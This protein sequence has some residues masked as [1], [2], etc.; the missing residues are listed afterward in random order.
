MTKMDRTGWGESDLYVLRLRNKSYH[1]SFLEE[2]GFISK[3]KRGAVDTA[4][5]VQAARKDIV[6]LDEGILKMAVGDNRSIHYNAVQ[7]SLKRHGGIARHRAQMLYDDTKDARI[8]EALGFFYDTVETNEDG[9]EQPTYDLS[10]PANVTYTA[11]GFLSHNTIGLLMDCD[12]TGIEPDFALVKFKK[13]AGGGYFK[14]V[15]QSIPK[16]LKH[17]GYTESQSKEIITYILGTSS[18]KKAPHIREEVLRAK[19]FNKDD[20]EK[21]ERVLPGSFELTQ[22]FSTHTLGKETMGRFGF[23][24]DQY[25]KPGFNLLKALGFS[26]PQIEEASLVICGRMTI[27][28]APHLCKEHLPIF[29]CAN[30]CGG[31]GKRYLAPMSHIRMMSSAQKFISGAISKTINLPNETTVED[32]EKL[33]VETWKLGLKS[34]ALY[35]DGCKLSQP[36]NATNDKQKETATETALAAQQQPTLKRHRLSKKRR[37]FTQEARIGGHKVYLRTG[38][39]EDGTLGELFIDMHKEGASFRSIMNCFAIAVSLGL[40][41]G[42]PL[43]EYVQ[44]FTFTRFEPQGTVDHPN[45]KMAT[46]VI[47]FIFRLLGMEYLG[48]TDFVQVKP[49]K[50][51]DVMMQIE[52]RTMDNGPLTKNKKPE[53]PQLKVI[54]PQPQNSVMNEHLSTMMGDAPF[55]DACGH[56]TVR[57]GSCYR[58][59]N[60][61]NSMGCS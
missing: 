12:T 57:N 51:E 61:G 45:I 6:Y 15:N 37:G 41:Y 49:N 24:E 18:L 34:V 19:G 56:V 14:I 1:A 13:L 39:Y 29:D 46:S 27:E 44:C 31:L 23:T 21:V 8:R 58:C 22:A 52:K 60:C 30:K 17:L 2:I 20:L 59:V 10:V 55:C 33:Y 50:D 4:D 5:Y 54:T 47:D 25:N 36:L 28:G 7:L 9:G 42:V 35:R 26:D 32:I 43:E 11:N 16:A 53:K 3:R 48:R 40:Q 38:E